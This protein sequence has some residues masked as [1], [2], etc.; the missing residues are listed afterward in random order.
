MVE[1]PK[2]APNAHN[3]IL[4]FSKCI[5]ATSARQKSNMN[6]LAG[7]QF[8]AF[9]AS[10]VVIVRKESNEP[11]FQPRSQ[12]STI[13]SPAEVEVVK[14]TPNDENLS[15]STLSIFKP[16]NKV[17]IA[18]EAANNESVQ[19]SAL[20][21]FETSG[22]VEVANN[23]PNEHS[24]PEKNQFII[25]RLCGKVFYGKSDL[26]IHLVCHS[27]A[28]QFI[29][30]ICKRPF[31]R[32]GNLQK[33]LR[34]HIPKDQFACDVC[35]MSFT[36]KA[37]L[38]KHILSHAY[39]CN[40]C[41]KRFASSQ[42]L[43][44]HARVHSTIDISLRCQYCG[45]LFQN[46]ENLTRHLA[47]HSD[48]KPYTCFICGKGYIRI[49][50][51]NSHVQL[52]VQEGPYACHIC[53]KRF[54]TKASLRWHSH[55]EDSLYTCDICDKWF[56][57]PRYFYNHLQACKEKRMKLTAT[58]IA[59]LGNCISS[60]DCPSELNATN[61]HQL[62]SDQLSIEGSSC[63]TP[64]QQTA[65]SNNNIPQDNLPHTNLYKQKSLS[66]NLLSEY[67]RRKTLPNTSPSK[68]TKSNALASASS[69]ASSS[70]ASEYARG[71]TASSTS[72][73]EYVRN[74]SLSSS[75]SLLKYERSNILSSTTP[76]TKATNVLTGSLPH[77]DAYH[78]KSDLKNQNYSLSERT[79]STTLSSSKANVTQFVHNAGSQYGNEMVASETVNGLWNCTICDSLF[80]DKEVY[81]FHWNKCYYSKYRN[82]I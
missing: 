28:Q 82:R 22:R 78:Q 80:S 18:Q 17:E 54:P 50:C 27:T 5:E 6:S 10:K 55:R 73:S 30:N 75:T 57:N 3:H 79:R 64:L 19:R 49:S 26:N 23:L 35:P 58:L 29:C 69:T 51:L 68:Y 7:S 11:S 14:D 4:N 40:I 38:E 46:K 36:L 72:P 74:K 63:V 2:N 34:T 47:V 59:T 48:I 71:I 52:H 15:S 77:A 67:T 41:N 62:L 9:S 45:K 60:P 53:G 42:S 33:H 20:S 76:H 70:S 56:V 43:N 61:R 8:P 31:S 12:I 16:S 24:S 81:M 32:K 66:N 37:D 65:T 25:C 1:I 21:I 13:N 44:S 39:S